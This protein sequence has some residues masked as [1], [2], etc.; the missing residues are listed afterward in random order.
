MAAS[1]WAAERGGEI[2]VSNSAETSAAYLN[3][4]RTKSKGC[5]K[6]AT[7]FSIFFY[8]SK[9]LLLIFQSSLELTSGIIFCNL[10]QDGNVISTC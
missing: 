2:D 7:E 10:F 6:S 5:Y 3:S 9:S 4:C 8:W 1:D